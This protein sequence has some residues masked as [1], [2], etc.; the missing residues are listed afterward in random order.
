MDGEAAK[1]TRIEVESEDRELRSAHCQGEEWASEGHE[2]RLQED[3]LGDG[4]AG[5]EGDGDE[6]VQHTLVDGQSH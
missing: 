5:E 2:H 4:K 6:G 3:Q 1:S